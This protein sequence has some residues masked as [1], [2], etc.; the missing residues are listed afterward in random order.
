MNVLI[1]GGAGYIG[2]VM[3][4]EFLRA[5][6]SVIVVDNFMYG[7]A[8]LLDCC[9]YR[10]FR[11]VR[12]DARDRRLLRDF[13]R[14]A[15]A[16]IPL[17]CLVGAPACDQRPSEAKAINFDAVQMLVEMTT[18]SQIVVWPNTNSG[19]G[20]GS[21]SR[22]CTEKSPLRPVSL[23]GRLKVELEKILMQR[24]NVTSLRLATAFGVSPRMR[25]D[26][27]VNDFTYRAVTDGFIVLF[28]SHF[29]RN[30]IHVRDVAR[31]FLHVIE[32]WDEMRGEIY[33]VG[34]S[35]A[36][37]SKLELCEVIKRHVP[38]LQI[39]EGEV[40]R[41]P[42]RRDYVVSNEKIEKTGYKPRVSL[43]DGID[44]LIRGY[45]VIRRN[46]YSNI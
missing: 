43:D 23:Y 34:L 8:S 6:H 38:K 37:L 16:V 24:G 13:V 26:L 9:S 11:I 12:G 27:L 10:N 15:D 42:D 39:I 3:V 5:G 31:A 45:Q 20:V 36:N 17:A 33:N 28:E 22:Y 29:R 2:S 14:D 44:E 35:D 7:Q 19:Y 46:Q 1:T 40:G 25:L 18:S 21:K 30:F 4:P 41:D 32:K